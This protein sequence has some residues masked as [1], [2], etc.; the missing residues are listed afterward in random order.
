MDII[1]LS[2]AKKYTDS[3]RLAYS[4]YDRD[5][6]LDFDGDITDKETFSGEALGVGGTFVHVSDIVFTGGTIISGSWKNNNGKLWK[7]LNTSV[8]T[9]DDGIVIVMGTLL[10]KDIIPVV[11]S[12]GSTIS[13]MLGVSAGTYFLTDD[14]YGSYC[15]VSSIMGR[16]IETIHTIDPK[17]LPK[18]AMGGIEKTVLYDGTPQRLDLTSH[19]LGILYLVSTENLLPLAEGQDIYYEY[20][21]NGRI[22]NGVIYGAPMVENGIVTTMSNYGSDSG[23]AVQ[24]NPDLGGFGFGLMLNS[25]G[26]DLGEISL[27]LWTEYSPYGNYVVRVV[28]SDAANINHEKMSKHILTGTVVVRS[29]IYSYPVVRSVVDGS[30]ISLFTIFVQSKA[31]SSS[32]YEV[33]RVNMYTFVDGVFQAELS[34]T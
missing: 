22:V 2:M 28:G 13:Q 4:A 33:G 9:T 29:N 27:K 14:I 20:T 7:I 23:V 25:A 5:I 1:T 10:G 30:N 12:F 3:Q 32:E 11:I 18:E 15:Y 34:S 31:N 8:I 6:T 19:G 24:Y 21:T 17:Y 26:V 16:F